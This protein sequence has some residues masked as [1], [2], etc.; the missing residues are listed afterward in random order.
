M[1]SHTQLPWE[2]IL[3]ACT[4]VVGWTL[5]LVGVNVVSFFFGYWIGHRGFPD[6]EQTMRALA[7]VPLVWLGSPTMIAAYVMTAITWYL[8]IQYDLPRARWALLGVDGLMWIVGI[9][10]VV[11]HTKGGKFFS[12]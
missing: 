12:F 2:A 4:S 5:T 1:K 8:P 6:W 7:F 10:S 9:Y 11:W 3:E